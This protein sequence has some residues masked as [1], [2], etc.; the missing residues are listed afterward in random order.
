M[1]RSPR[2]APAINCLK[3]V[4]FLHLAKYFTW[5][6]SP[7]FAQ[8]SVASLTGEVV[9]K[10]TFFLNTSLVDWSDCFSNKIGNR[11]EQWNIYKNIF[12]GDCWHGRSHADGARSIPCTISE[13][14]HRFQLVQASH[15]LT[16]LPNHTNL[17]LLSVRNDGD[18]C[19]GA[20]ETPSRVHEGCGQTGIY[21][22][23]EGEHW[24]LLMIAT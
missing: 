11:L 17:Y 7:N 18:G 21:C 10:R 22:A 15:R 6:D 16:N 24:W 5:N 20:I 1:S 4:R 3:T 19:V 2:N 23:N 12:L 13:S 8:H 9:M 14:E